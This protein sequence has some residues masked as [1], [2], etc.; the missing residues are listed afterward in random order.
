[1]EDR[2]QIESL[3]AAGYVDFAASGEDAAGEFQCAECGYG[4]AVHRK[5]PQ[6]PMCGGTAWERAG[7][8]A[9]A[10]PLQ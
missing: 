9:F 3:E 8:G 1:M 7:R 4:I 6:C 2:G 5:L 10:G